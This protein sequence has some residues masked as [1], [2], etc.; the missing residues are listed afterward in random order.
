MRQGVLV[1]SDRT[2]NQQVEESVGLDSA[3][4]RYHKIGAGV[5]A[6]SPDMSPTVVRGIATLKLYQETA[7]LLWPILLPAQREVI[8]QTV[9]V[10]EGGGF[11]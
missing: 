1:K 4:T 7:T 3:W 6:G 8:G 9:R 2:F 5:D 10:I 11:D